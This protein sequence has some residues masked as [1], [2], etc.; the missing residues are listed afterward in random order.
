MTR[1]IDTTS[2]SSTLKNLYSI[3]LSSQQGVGWY[4]N[5][6]RWTNDWQKRQ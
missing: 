3:L 4:L 6:P 2:E 5:A 1:T